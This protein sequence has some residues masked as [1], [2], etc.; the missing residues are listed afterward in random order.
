MMLDP[1]VITIS[2]TAV[3]IVALSKS[4]LLGSLGMI[5]VPL[6][7]FVM[8]AREAAGMMLP[9]LLVMDTVGLIAYRKQID[10]KLLKIMIPGALVGIGIGWALFSFISD[11]AVLLLVGLIS[12][13]FVLDEWLPFRKKLEGLPPSTFWGRF[14]GA[15]TGFTSFVSHTGGP[16]FQVYV[17]PQKLPP[18]I[19]A[20]TQVW[21]FSIVNAVKLIPYFFLGQI[22]VTSLK[23]SAMLAPVGIIGM[24][25]GVWLM[26]R[27]PASIFYRMSYVLI[28]IVA[29]KLIYDGSLD[30]L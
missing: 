7:T 4:G 9:V 8:P 22:S 3:M 16:P 10:L 24:L 5:G 25:I 13:I 19:Y 17:L 27:I 6:L 29:L 26:K 30:L 1:Y 21:M 18:A 11:A 15:L 23:T 2:V 28:F 14:W 12:L 20:G